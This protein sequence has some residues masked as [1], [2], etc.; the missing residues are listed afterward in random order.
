MNKTEKRSGL[1]Q[2]LL[3]TIGRSGLRA[4]PCLAGAGA[5]LLAAAPHQA[6]ALNLY[7]GSAAGNNLEINLTSTV[8]YSVFERVNSPSAILISPTGNAN[9]SEGDL[10]FQHGII[11]NEFEILPVLDIKDG[12]FGIHASGE[13][14]LNTPYLG[15]NQNDQ[16][17][18]FN[19]F[20]PGKSTDFTSATRN[21]NGEDAKLL[22]AFAFGRHEF[23]NGQQL[24]LKV[25][26]STLFW[27]QS[28]F[29][30]ADAIAGGQG[31]T[32]IIT[33]QSLPN[34]QAQQVFLP[35]GQAIVTY[36]PL[37]GTGITIQGYYQFEWEHDNFQGVGAYFNSADLLDKGGQRLILGPGEYAYRTK[38]L[39]PPAEN[40]QFGIS[41]QAPVGNYDVGLYA[42]RFDA[43][44][45]QVYLFPGNGL[46]PAQKGFQVGTYTL[47][48]PRDIA[49]Y[50][51][52]ASTNLGS[53][54]VAGEIS[55]R[56]NQPLDSGGGDSGGPINIQTAANPGNASSDPLY[57][58]GDTLNA[59]F[60]WIDV[61]PGIPLDPGGVTFEGEVG[62]THVLTVTRNRDMLTQGRQ[63]T[64][65]TTSFEIIPA[66]NDVIPNLDL[67]FPIGIGYNF[68]GRSEIDSTQNHGTGDFNVGVS[69][70]YNEV[71][72]ASL[73][74]YDYLG[75][76]N[77]NL[78]P[79][80]DRGY[81][82]FNVQRTF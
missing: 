58:T 21:V 73:V 30:Y 32:D 76:A 42:L 61:T 75:H 70:T 24:S 23:G 28:L 55:G 77:T 9:G 72:T 56:T 36:Q 65:G 4:Y 60:S 74:Y 20:T 15:T 38:D 64:A 16:P 14:Y 19:P 67:T 7:S 13:A 5:L 6:R 18:T 3:A 22:D 66:Y 26:R 46:G 8:E 69:G 12:D 53:A 10:A 51:A 81:V 79:L 48:Y 63:A 27:G 35:V 17:G 29:L 57:A 43:K 11:A 71:W 50:G 47:V 68:L 82:E 31:P 49:I 45:P 37:P 39:D 40:G 2:N 62:F 41:V 34:A 52:S 44:T 59:Q 1:K 25:G 78:N 80:A 33:A 54:N